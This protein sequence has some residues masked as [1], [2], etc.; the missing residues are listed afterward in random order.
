MFMQHR[1]LL[2]GGG[3]KNLPPILAQKGNGDR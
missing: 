2:K 3:R 1:S